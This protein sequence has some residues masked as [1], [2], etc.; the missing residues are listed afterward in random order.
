M[1][2]LVVIQL[3]ALVLVVV[4]DVL[5]TFGFVVHHPVRPPAGFLFD[6]QPRVDVVSEEA[7]LGLGEIPHLVDVL[8]LAPQLDGLLQLGGAPHTGQD[9]LL[10]GVNALVGSLQRRFDHFFFH[11]GS[12]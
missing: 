5:T 2:D 3:N 8:D 9:S 6:L 7:F 1:L 12:A 10:V 4:V 11:A